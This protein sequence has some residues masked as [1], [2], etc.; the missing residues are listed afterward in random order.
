MNMVLISDTPQVEHP[1]PPTKGRLEIVIDNDI[2]N[3]LDLSQV[4]AILGN[5]ISD[6][7]GE[8]NLGDST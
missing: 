8:K 7:V 6:D 3:N 5:S 1:L 4:H 2:I